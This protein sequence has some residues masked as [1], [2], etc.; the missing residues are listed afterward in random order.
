MMQMNPAGEVLVAKGGWTLHS[1][2]AAAVAGDG[3]EDVAAGN[4]GGAGCGGDGYCGGCGCGSD[5]PSR[6]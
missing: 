1:N 3:Y 2:A 4:G 5:G 6:E